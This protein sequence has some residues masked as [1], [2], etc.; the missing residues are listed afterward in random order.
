M[1]NRGVRGG[2]SS[3]GERQQDDDQGQPERGGKPLEHD[4]LHLGRKEAREA[5]A[6]RRFR[7]AGDSLAQVR[8]AGQDAGGLSRRHW[9]DERH[10]GRAGGR[11]CGAAQDASRPAKLMPGPGAGAH[12]P[13]AGQLV[14]VPAAEMFAVQNVIS[15]ALTVIVPVAV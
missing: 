7:C 13:V 10:A 14:R 12:P 11:Y 4:D 1:G 6:G 15:P 8:G 2:Q 9:L 3:H 5:R